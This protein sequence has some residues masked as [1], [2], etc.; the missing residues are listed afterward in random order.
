MLTGGMRLERHKRRQPRAPPHTDHDD[1]QF[2]RQLRQ[3]PPRKSTTRVVAARCRPHPPPTLGRPK[4]PSTVDPG[5]VTN[6]ETDIQNHC[7]DVDRDVDPDRNRHARTYQPGD[8]SPR[9]SDNNGTK[10]G[11]S[12]GPAAK[13]TD[14]PG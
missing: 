3:W 2:G 1:D 12:S 6:T 4:V 8:Q 14:T 10:T 9:A 13:V 11:L 5:T 7:P